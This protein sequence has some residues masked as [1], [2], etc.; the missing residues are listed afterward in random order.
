MK[1]IGHILN[2]KKQT[3]VSYFEISNANNLSTFSWDVI[4]KEY[5]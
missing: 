2:K 1:S 4:E 5:N 3:P